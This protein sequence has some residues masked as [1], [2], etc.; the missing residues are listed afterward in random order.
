MN[1]A[2]D[3]AN[4]ALDAIGWSGT[5]LGDIE[6]GTF[7]AQ[8][9]LRAY[10]QCRKQLLRAVHWNFARMEAPM[11][12][13]GDR[14][15]QTLNVGTMVPGGWTYI[16]AYPTNCLKMR[17]VPWNWENQGNGVPQGN[18]IPPNSASPQTTGDQQPI[19]GPYIRPAKFVESTDVNYPPLPGQD[20]DGVQGVSAQ[21]RTVILTNVKNARAVYTADMLYPNVWDALFRAAMVAYLASEVALPVWSKTDR[22][23]GLIIR[24][25]QSEI[26]KAKVLQARITDGN[27]GT[28]GSDISVDWMRGRRVGGSA[29]WW[30]GGSWSGGGGDW[31]NFC[32][33]DGL[34]L[35]GEVF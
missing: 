16:Y 20:L 2:T 9:L 27:S 29:S 18:I 3:I 6:D 28:P 8:V 31:G 13:L 24:K 7:P 23:F 26:V 10:S 19:V 33:Y 4:Q 5:P 30:G 12:L 32:G 21:G 15:G 25:E 35:A 1:L 11:T 22:K 14:T 34:A 17:F